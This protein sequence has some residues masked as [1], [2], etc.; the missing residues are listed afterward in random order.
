MSKMTNA[1]TIVQATRA[2]RSRTGDKSIAVQVERGLF[3]VVRVTYRKG[4]TGQ[5]AALS[6]WVKGYEAVDFLNAL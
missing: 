5:V 2:A 3:R 1:P 4:G 6:E